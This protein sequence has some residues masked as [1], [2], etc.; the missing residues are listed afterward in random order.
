M[1]WRGLERSGNLEDRRGRSA[2]AVAGGVGGLGIIGALLVMFLSGGGEGGDLGSLLSQLQEPAPQ[3][4]QQLPPA[5]DAAE[6]YSAILGTTETVWSEVFDA[7]GL[8]YEPAQLVLFTDRTESGCGG[9][10]SA[11]GPHYCPN[12]QTIYIDLVFFNELTTRFGASG[13]DFA[14]AYVLAHEVGHHIQNV[15]GTMDEV[16]N[17]QTQDPSQA[18][19]YSVSLELQADCYAGVWA[20]SIFQRDAVLEQ[21]DI[22]EG[23]DAAAAVGDDRIQERATGQIQPEKFTHGTSQQRV[24]WFNVGY[25]S[26]APGSCDTFGADS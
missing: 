23:L 5:D 26:G 10:T 16:R 2:G 25:Q 17:L 18:N 19:S 8:Q 14:E 1:K 22:E 21:G 13:G 6:F 7:N 20:N 3:T 9:A 15:V 11:I 4:E 24:D 12:D